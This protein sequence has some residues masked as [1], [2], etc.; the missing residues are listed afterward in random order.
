[1]MFH[2]FINICFDEKSSAINILESATNFL[3]HKFSYKSVTE[4][5]YFIKSWLKGHQLIDIQILPNL[6]QF[7][8]T[9][10]GWAGE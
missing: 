10:I 6:L 4:K 9:I 8:S 2:D 3:S 7:L 1:M 5:F